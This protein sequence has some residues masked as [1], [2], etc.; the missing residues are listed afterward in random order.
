[1][2]TIIE[3]GNKEWQAL[4]AEIEA[5]KKDPEWVKELKQF[6]KITSS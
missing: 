1:M 3:S 6:I 5:A 4:M 2:G